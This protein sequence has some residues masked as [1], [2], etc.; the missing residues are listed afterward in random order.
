MLRGGTGKERASEEDFRKAGV[1]RACAHIVAPA[2]SL[3]YK[4][5]ALPRRSQHPGLPGAELSQH[6]CLPD[7]RAEKKISVRIFEKA[8]I[9]LSRMVFVPPEHVL[10]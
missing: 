6:R 8:C 10:Q 2:L 1:T 3:H 4:R 9:F 7:L 5:R